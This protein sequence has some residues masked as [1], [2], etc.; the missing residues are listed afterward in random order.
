MSS[1]RDLVPLTVT[2]SPSRSQYLYFPAEKDDKG[3]VVRRLIVFRESK[4][5]YVNADQIE[6]GVDERE[7]CYI[8]VGTK[9]KDLVYESTKHEKYLSEK[10]HPKSK[11]NHVMNVWASKGWVFDVKGNPL[12]SSLPA[13]SEQ[14][15]V[16]T[17]TPQNTQGKNNLFGNTLQ[18]IAKEKTAELEASNKARDGKSVSSNPQAS[19]KPKN[20][21]RKRKDKKVGPFLVSDSESDPDFSSGLERKP[22]NPKPAA[23]SKPKKVGGENERAVHEKQPIRNE[24]LNKTRDSKKI[25]SPLSISSKPTD[26]RTPRRGPPKV[27]DSES[28]SDSL[29]VSEKKPAHQKSAVD[30]KRRK[31]IRN[32][33]ARELFPSDEDDNSTSL[34]PRHKSK[35]AGGKT[36]EPTKPAKKTTTNTDLTG[37]KSNRREGRERSK[38][39]RVGATGES[40]GGTARA[41]DDRS[42]SPERASR[43]PE[44]QRQRGDSS[45]TSSR[46]PAG[47]A[48]KKEST[49]TG[50]S[51]SSRTRTGNELASTAGLYYESKGAY[52]QG[53][54]TWSTEEI[55]PNRPPTE[56]ELRD[57]ELE[58]ARRTWKKKHGTE[59]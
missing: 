55:D 1:S 37:D 51:R 28:D 5:E 30:D 46:T 21:N 31:A 57:M 39:E 23:D 35:T 17:G 34:E 59:L 22:V 40:S 19:S 49:S 43:K 11:M 12:P 20:A 16:K 14:S 56:K 7:K 4:V 10:H 32:P 42:K 13:L 53:R 29:F 41:R 25:S 27:L 8:K 54:K 45:R 15:S 26:A 9:S 6:P 38:F 18:T 50:K 2:I 24:A 33:L 47:V 3:R 52:T 44:V 58:D 48:V 36:I